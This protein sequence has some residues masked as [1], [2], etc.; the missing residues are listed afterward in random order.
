[1]ISEPVAT[2]LGWTYH[3]PN[4]NLTPFFTR[5]L[6]NGREVQIFATVETG[7]WRLTATFNGAR[8]FTW[9]RDVKHVEAAFARAKVLA[10]ENGGWKAKAAND[11]FY[12]DSE[13]LDPE[14]A[15]V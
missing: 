13:D 3:R 4:P 14:G 2:A 12:D 6:A 5:E 7:R 10:E 1:M 8:I 9:P 11:P 15:V